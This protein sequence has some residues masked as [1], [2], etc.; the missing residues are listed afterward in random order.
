MGGK[1]KLCGGV[2]GPLLRYH[3]PSL[4]W[5]AGMVK[6]LG[7][8]RFVDGVEL[9]K[10]VCTS[11][12]T[13]RTT[14]CAVHVASRMSFALA[15]PPAKVLHSSSRKHKRC[16]FAELT[17]RSPSCLSRSLFLSFFLLLPNTEPT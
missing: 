8:W 6:F 7:K 5:S 17:L 12:S 11:T 10:W 9:P 16:L 1:S 4:A 13:P 3:K 14:Y 15:Q 2:A